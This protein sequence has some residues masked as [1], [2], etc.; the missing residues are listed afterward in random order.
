MPMFWFIDRQE[1][2]AFRLYKSE[3]D[4]IAKPTQSC[5]YTASLRGH[6]KATLKKYIRTKSTLIYSTVVHASQ[7]I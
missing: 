4:E 7:A 3:Q 5:A 1:E 2:K 6:K